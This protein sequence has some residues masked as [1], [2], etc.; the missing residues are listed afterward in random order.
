MDTGY[1]DNKRDR[2]FGNLGATP[3]EYLSHKDEP[4]DRSSAYLAKDS[5]TADYSDGTANLFDDSEAEN[6]KWIQRARRYLHRKS[7]NRS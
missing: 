3:P 7:R 5:M 6:G 1:T 2:S 4:M